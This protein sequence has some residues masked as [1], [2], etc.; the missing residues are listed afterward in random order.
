MPSH[1]RPGG[2]N[3]KPPAWHV[4]QIRAEQR[5]VADL[6]GLAQ[7]PPSRLLWGLEDVLQLPTRPGA[8]RLSAARREALLLRLESLR[9]LQIA[10]ALPGLCADL[11]RFG[12]AGGDPPPDVQRLAYLGRLGIAITDWSVRRPARDPRSRR[13]S[14]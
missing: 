14:Q 10:L 9:D 3:H 2:R 5:R 1:R 13:V 8:P 7:W 12:V 11:E 6:L 4:D